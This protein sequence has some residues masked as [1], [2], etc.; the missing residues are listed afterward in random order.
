MND[1]EKIFRFR[2]Y[3]DKK[4]IEKFDIA[5]DLL[6]GGLDETGAFLEGGQ[7]H[8]LLTA[9]A[10]QKGIEEAFGD[11]LERRVCINEEDTK[12]N[13]TNQL[14]CP[15]QRSIRAQ[16]TCID[17]VVENNGLNCQQ[18]SKSGNC[19]SLKIRKIWEQLIEENFENR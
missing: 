19:S 3:A 7:C 17:H 18:I 5:V 4:I 10:H 1:I 11:L 8:A 9:L 2:D 16:I 13:W 14:A 6:K 12:P 15:H